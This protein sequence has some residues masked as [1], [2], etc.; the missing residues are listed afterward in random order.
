MAILAC[1]AL[2]SVARG[3]RYDEVGGEKN[4]A[5]SSAISLSA[6]G[7]EAWGGVPN[8]L[9]DDAAEGFLKLAGLAK[10]LLPTL[11]QRGGVDSP[12]DAA[13]KYGTDVGEA[14]STFILEENAQ[15]PR[16]SFV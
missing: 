4:L 12:A 15:Q 14:I 13:A 6:Q 1:A 7:C 11:A 5:T 9:S 8:T 2:L 16:V 3:F 10:K